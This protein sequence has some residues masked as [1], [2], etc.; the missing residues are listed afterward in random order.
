M[1][2]PITIPPPPTYFFSKKIS[3][4]PSPPPLLLGPPR[5]LIF[6]FFLEKPKKGSRC[7]VRKI[8][9]EMCKQ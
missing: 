1:K 2:S 9:T 7:Y 6:R 4:L 5:L 3:D 8:L